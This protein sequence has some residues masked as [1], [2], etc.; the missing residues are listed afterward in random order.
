MRFYATLLRMG[1]FRLGISQKCSGMTLL[2][3]GTAVLAF[4]LLYWTFL[5]FLWMLYGAYR[6]IAFIV[7]AIKKEIPVK[8]KTQ[9]TFPAEPEQENIPAFLQSNKVFWLSVFLFPPLSVFIVYLRDDIPMY[10]RII[11]G[12]IAFPSALIWILF[13]YAF[14]GI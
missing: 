5:A 9:T 10:R 8:T 12:I 7:S 11:R 2:I 13:I 6:L 3:V 4:Y 14:F 1:N